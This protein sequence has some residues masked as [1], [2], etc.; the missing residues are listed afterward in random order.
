MALL[1]LL[2]LPPTPFVQ[3]HKYN[4]FSHVHPTSKSTYGQN[5]PEMNLD[6]VLSY[7]QRKL[8]FPIH[9]LLLAP[10]PSSLGSPGEESRDSSTMHW[11]VVLLRGRVRSSGG[12][13]G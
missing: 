8:S 6:E 12:I 11:R 5:F 10:P 13:Q 1:S 2:A 3:Q 9:L 7:T 4:T